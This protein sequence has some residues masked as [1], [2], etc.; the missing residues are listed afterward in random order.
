V[1]GILSVV[2]KNI[3]RM[4]FKTVLII[5]VMAIGVS[6]YCIVIN[7]N[8]MVDDVLDENILKAQQA[9][10]IRVSPNK[11]QFTQ[12]VSINNDIVDSIYK[13]SNVDNV[14]SHR[15][16]SAVIFKSNQSIEAITLTNYPLDKNKL[17]TGED[18]RNMSNDN[19]II[20]PDLT[21]VHGSQATTC[22]SLVGKSIVL[23]VPIYD[24]NGVMSTEKKFDAIV[25]GVYNAKGTLEE[26]PSF[27]KESFLLKML[28]EKMG[29]KNVEAFEKNYPYDELKVY[30]NSAENVSAV[31]SKIEAMNLRTM[32]LEKDLKHFATNIK[33]VKMVGKIV[34]FIV[35]GVG[36]SLLI[37]MMLLNVKT[38]Q[39]EIGI[40]KAIGFSSMYI[41]GMLF[42]ES[43][44]LVI[45]GSVISFG[46]Q[47]VAYPI[48]NCY[49]SKWGLS[50]RL[51]I[52]HHILLNIL[53]L[54]VV[55]SSVAAVFPIKKCC[56]LDPI[57]VLKGE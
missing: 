43:I 49:I 28:T 51:G 37:N 33:G 35:M 18:F 46:L 54:L 26:N 34:G 57:D 52:T 47:L 4:K 32:Y 13:I 44:F 8:E 9:R 15:Y 31:A 22:K 25:G 55:L 27:L 6:A 2:L 41:S 29:Y 48:L 20:L 30:V 53:A 23:K 42:F 24:K 36:L 50:G 16:I 21:L 45:L 14:V 19:V 12:H 1:N 56:R 5:L 40:M 39:K 3:R 17:A 10:E 38:R 7:L 11:E